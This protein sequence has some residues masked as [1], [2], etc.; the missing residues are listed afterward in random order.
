MQ[1]TERVRARDTDL[2]RH[3]YYYYFD[4]YIIRLEIIC[5]KNLACESFE[6]NFNLLHHFVDL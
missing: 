3:Y 6:G 4:L 5:S 2:Q 1:R